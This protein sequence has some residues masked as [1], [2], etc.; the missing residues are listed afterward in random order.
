MRPATLTIGLVFITRASNVNLTAKMMANVRGNTS[1][2]TG[3]MS[4]TTRTAST[5]W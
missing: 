5:R 3:G 2:L 1:D 4:G